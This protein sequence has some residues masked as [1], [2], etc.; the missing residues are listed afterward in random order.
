ERMQECAHV[1]A[2]HLDGVLPAHPRHGLRESK[3]LD[4]VMPQGG[5]AESAIYIV[6]DVDLRQSVDLC[7]AG[8]R[9]HSQDLGIRLVS[10][11]KMLVGHV[12]TELRLQ[13]EGRREDVRLCDAT[14]V[15]RTVRAQRKTRHPF[16]KRSEIELEAL[17]PAAE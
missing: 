4:V 6:G 11:G 8:D 10:E 17:E 14:R 9:L 13:N 2:A 15:F 5:V 16:T 1:L 12:D 7:D 3:R